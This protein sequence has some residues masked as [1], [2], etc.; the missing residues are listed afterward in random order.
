MCSVV[1]AGTGIFLS[2]LKFNSLMMNLR[3][4]RSEHT[5]SFAIFRADLSFLLITKFRLILTLNDLVRTELGRPGE[6]LADI[7]DL[8]MG[9]THLHTVAFNARDI[10]KE[11]TL[12]ALKACS[13]QDFINLRVL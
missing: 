9:L 10:N 11:C 13:S 5:A 12:E 8:S 4:V 7:L 3:T 6:V 2:A 1:K